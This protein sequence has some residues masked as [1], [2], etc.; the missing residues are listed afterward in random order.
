MV[1]EQEL[2]EDLYVE[3]FSDAQY[4]HHPRSHGGHPVSYAG[5]AGTRLPQEWESKL[6]GSTGM[7]SGVTESIQRGRCARVMVKLKRI[8]RRPK[9]T[10]ILA[11]TAR[12]RSLDSRGGSSRRLGAG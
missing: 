5:H 4:D 10:Q 6:Q 9:S 8:N 7:N 2:W 11:A 12:S 3:G 1:A